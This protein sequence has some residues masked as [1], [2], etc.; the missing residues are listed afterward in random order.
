LTDIPQENGAAVYSTEV[1]S[2][3]AQ[4]TKTHY[5]LGQDVLVTT[6]DKIRI[7][8]T[9]CAANIESRKAWIAPAGILVTIITAYL[10]T[11]FKDTILKA[12]VWEA[13]FILAALGCFGWLLLT[14]IRLKKVATV[15]N[16]IAEI[17]KSSAQKK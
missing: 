4:E 8:L 7:V 12:A 5:N 14:L 16:I 2:R 15:D 17:K 1:S 11:T 6:E 10:N 3:I 9:K 13:L